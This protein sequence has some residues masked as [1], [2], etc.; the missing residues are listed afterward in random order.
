MY[1]PAP[2]LSWQTLR[3]CRSTD[4]HAGSVNTA[5]G[6]A[7][8]AVLPSL[9][10]EAAV[11]AT[12]WLLPLTKL[13]CM[14][15]S[16][17][18]L[19]RR[20]GCFRVSEWQPR[21]HTGLSGH[22]EHWQWRWHLGRI[23]VW[24]RRDNDASERSSL[25]CSL[26]ACLGAILTRHSRTGHA[27]EW[28]WHKGLIDIALTCD[29]LSAGAQTAAAAM[30]DP[31]APPA[32]RAGHARS[33]SAPGPSPPPVA[34]QPH[35]GTASAAAQ[36]PVGRGAAAGQQQDPFAPS[37]S[38]RA[39]SSGGAPPTALNGAAGGPQS[40]TVDPF[41]L[42]PQAGLSAASAAA[43]LAATPPAQVLH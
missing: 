26:R 42:K 32:Q 25:R 38:L 29:L 35:N 8:L 18:G 21:Q 27:D 20:L 19:Y 11:E 5:A 9:A 31:F 3:S 10:D 6:I 33:Y 2:R 24:R 7:S 13:L 12:P 23:P 37:S 17:R 43:R 40:S 4:A 15:C 28:L 36:P 22:R 41:A 14:R 39:T 1:G 16:P 34:P 30:S